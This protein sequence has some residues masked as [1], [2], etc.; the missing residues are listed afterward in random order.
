MYKHLIDNNILPMEQR[1]CLEGAT[2]CKDLLMLDKIITEDCKKKYK[3]LSVAWID[4]LKAYDNCPHEWMVKV[5][6]MYKIDLKSATFC[7]FCVFHGRRLVIVMS[8]FNNSDGE[9]ITMSGDCPRDKRG[10]PP[11][12]GKGSGN[13]TQDDG[14]S[15]CNL[16]NK[17]NSKIF[18]CNKPPVYLL[19]YNITLTQINIGYIDQYESAPE[20][21]KQNCFLNEVKDKWPNAYLIF[22]D[23]SKTSESVASAFYDT[24]NKNSGTFKLQNFATIFTAEAFAI[25]QALKY[26]SSIKEKEVIIITDSKSCLEKLKNTSKS[27]GNPSHLI[28]DIFKELSIY[29][30]YYNF[31][32]HQAGY[33]KVSIRESLWI[34]DT[35]NKNS[36]TFKL[37]NFATI[38]T[39]EAFAILQALKYVSSIKENE[40]IIITDSKSCLEKLK[41]TSKSNGNPS[42]LILDIFKALSHLQEWNISVRFIWVRGHAGIAGNEAVDRL[43]K[44]TAR[45]T[46]ALNP[47]PIPVQ[48]VRAVTDMQHEIQWR[49][50]VMSQ[51]NNKGLFYKN[52]FTI[53]DKK[54]WFAKAIPLRKFI[55]TFNRLRSNHAICQAY[56]HKIN[57]APTNL[58][59][60]CLEREDMA[61]II[62]CCPKYQ[63]KRLTLFKNIEGILEHPFNY[64][65]LI[66]NPSCYSHIFKFLNKIKITP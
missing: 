3:N 62:L 63:V 22:T 7:V 53:T 48:D 20:Y 2:G 26:A 56:L 5:I 18:T 16:S 37:K 28:L 39:A 27:N 33:C 43:A 45:G 35:Q 58:C 59:Q 10:I 11:D 21:A 15:Y 38:F 8:D 61:H 17:Y 6:Q 9:D 47:Y 57:I 54:P 1:G 30:L 29:Y 24:Q 34:F 51:N 19:E 64:G 66:Q 14:E 12:P 13:A 42:H 25:L 65:L 46:D 60:E 36:G 32:I 52:L 50:N 23:G 40:V 41:N 4:L 49:E 31:V 44:E 55:V